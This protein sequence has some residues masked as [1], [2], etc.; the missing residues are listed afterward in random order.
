MLCLL[1]PGP[2]V[3]LRGGMERVTS[4]ALMMT[5]SHLLSW[6][7]N[8]HVRGPWGYWLIPNGKCGYI[9]ATNKSVHVKNM[10]KTTVITIFFFFFIEL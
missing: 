1:W 3:G 10:S 9:Y 2:I 4:A 5:P 8:Q 6:A 7:G